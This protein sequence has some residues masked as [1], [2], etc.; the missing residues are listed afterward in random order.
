MLAASPPNRQLR[1]PADNHTAL[2]TPPLSQFGHTALYRAVQQGNEVAMMA[3]LGAGASPDAT[4]CSRPPLLA[5]CELHSLASASALLEH[6]ADVAQAGPEGTTPVMVAA[7]D[8]CVS[9]L[10]TLL[11]AKAPPSDTDAEGRSALV[12]AI[13]AGKLHTVQLLLKAGAGRSAIERENALNRAQAMLGSAHATQ[14]SAD[15]LAAVQGL[16]AE[17]GA[18]GGHK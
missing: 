7:R 9:L 16:L 18:S 10:S 6:G 11:S 3:L 12:H 14:S 2:P 4:G 13:E 8:G 1:K 5:A 17:A 15:I